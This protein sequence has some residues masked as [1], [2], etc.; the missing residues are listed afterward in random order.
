MINNIKE[1]INKNENFIILPHKS[2]DGDT[3]GSAVALE[4]LL[5]S[6]DKKGYIILDDDIPLNLLF[7][8]PILYSKADFE[9]ENIDYNVVITLDSSDLSR[10]ESRKELLDNKKVINIDHHITNTEYGDINYVKEASSV[11]E[12]LYDLFSKLNYDINKEVA[13]GLY[14]AISTDTG[15]FK[16]NN[17]TDQT[18]FIAS[19]LRKKVDFEKI[20]V[21]LYQN[22]LYDEV[23]LHSRVLETLKCYNEI[24]IIYLTNEMREKLDLQNE[25]TD[26]LVEKVR[27]INGIEIAVFLK[28]V[29]EKRFKVSLR[30][31]HDF[32][33]SKLAFK[34][35]GGGHKKAA[36]CS[37]EGELKNIIDLLITEIKKGE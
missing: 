16:Y 31:K 21:E 6:M 19:Q 4:R 26:G 2:P 30:S 18:F 35:N 17:T 28:E 10:V 12:I 5:Y 24:G 25:N 8:N 1:I 14:V 7:L 32:D 23:K 22:T 3:L 33:V 34:Y 29:D 9:K 36:G 20:N 27:N 37:M 15:S 13:N 11:G